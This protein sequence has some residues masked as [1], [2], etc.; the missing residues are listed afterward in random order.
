MNARAAD[1][2]TPLHIAAKQY[3]IY[4]RL[5]RVLID[6]GANLNATDSSGRTPLHVLA[7]GQGRY[8]KSVI[9][10]LRSRNARLDLRDA[11]GRRP[12]DA[13]P[14][15]LPASDVIRR[16]LEVPNERPAGN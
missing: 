10:L 8:R 2:S 11:N 12:V 5:T 4:K 3:R 16:L 7:G 13:V 15:G 6:A 14:D 1:G 9:Q